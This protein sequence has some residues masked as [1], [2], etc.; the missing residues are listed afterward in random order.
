M[1]T[2]APQQRRVI[3]HRVD[4]LNQ[5]DKRFRFHRATTS[6]GRSHW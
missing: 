5:Q 1:E 2:G 6:G 4:G 3:V